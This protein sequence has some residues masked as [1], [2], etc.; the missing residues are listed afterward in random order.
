MAEIKSAGIEEFLAL[1]D[2]FPVFDVRTPAEYE[3]GH[4]PGAHNLPLFSD[5]ER[6]LVGTTY[7]KAGREAAVLEG[8][9]YV[10]PK[11]RQMI[12]TVQKVTPGKTV[13]LLCWRGGMRSSSVAWLLN[14]YGYEVHLLKGGYKAF[15]NY[16]LQTFEIPRNIII[17][18]GHTGS[19]KSDVLEQLKQM[20]EQVIDLEG[21]AHHKGSAFG[22][23][24]ELPQPT[25]QKFE[26]Q[27]AFLWRSVDAERPLWLE[28]ESQKIGSRMI[29]QPL[30]QQM[31][32]ARV[33]FLKVPFESRVERLTREYGVFR[34][35]E[36]VESIEK[37]RTRLGGLQ[38]KKALEALAQDD[39]KLCCEILLRHYYDKTYLHGLNRRN[40]KTIYTL[41]TDTP[42][43][44]KNA[45]RL[46]A[47]SKEILEETISLNY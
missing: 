23:L 20:E 31:R 40:P 47:F 44:Q 18:S 13:L 27:L 43:P 16:V 21:L 38:V 25:Q 1:R 4:I 36:L 17:L 35:T 30:W 10:G 2:R 41:E 9:E 6:A 37:L 39:L 5:V 42:D 34:K 22:G 3:K 8:L 15:R 24:G 46:L 7:Q 45:E 33:I 32:N 29:P 12:E 19:G 11:M 28:D 26:N 14:V